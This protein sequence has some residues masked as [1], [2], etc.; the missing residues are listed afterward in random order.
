VARTPW[1]RLYVR[2]TGNRTS[3]ETLPPARGPLTETLIDHLRG[4]AEL[5]TELTVEVDARTDDDLHLAL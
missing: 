1:E 3:M 5:R 4:E 2:P